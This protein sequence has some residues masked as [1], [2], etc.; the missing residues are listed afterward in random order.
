MNREEFI[1]SANRKHA[2]DGLPGLAA[3]D[4]PELA[5]LTNQTR[6]LNDEYHENDAD[7]PGI[8]EFLQQKRARIREMQQE[9]SC[10]SCK[11]KF[12]P[13]SDRELYLYCELQFPPPQ[14]YCPACL[15][16]IVA[17]MD[18]RQSPEGFRCC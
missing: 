2:S 6:W 12:A 9:R 15:R 8:R 13:A 1:K 14:D 4:L 18:E 16:K 5:K 7:N 17:L 10:V 3:R 11:Q